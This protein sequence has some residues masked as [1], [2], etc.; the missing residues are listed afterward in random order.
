MDAYQ[1]IISKRDRRE[2]EPK[3]IP[4]DVLQRILQA[5]RMAGPVLWVMAARERERLCPAGLAAQFDPARLVIAR[6]TGRLGVLQVMEEALRSGALPLVIGELDRAT[7]LT[8]SRRLQLA[9]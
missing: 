3:P 1:A 4:E 5:G 6:P 9:D 8:Q 2:Y 7:D